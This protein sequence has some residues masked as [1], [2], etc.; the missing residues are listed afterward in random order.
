MSCYIFY[1]CISE[2]KKKTYTGIT[3]NSFR[4]LRQHRGEIK[5]GAKWPLSWKGLCFYG[6]QI[7]GFVSDRMCR[8]FELHTKNKWRRKWNLDLQLKKWCQEKNMQPQNNLQKRICSILHLLN[9]EK[10]QTQN[11]QVKWF[12]ILENEKNILCL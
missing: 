4:R 11:L 6:L 1:L 8:S 7:S 5:G 2:D 10:F 3:K 12:S 9:L